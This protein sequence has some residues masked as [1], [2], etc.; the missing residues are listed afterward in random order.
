MLKI[1][2]SSNNLLYIHK[3]NNVKKQTRFI[4]GTHLLNHSS[5]L[6]PFINAPH[7]KPLTIKSPNT[8]FKNT[9]FDNTDNLSNY[10]TKLN[11]MIDTLFN[12]ITTD[13]IDTNFTS[14]EETDDFKKYLLSPGQRLAVDKALDYE[15]NESLGGVLGLSHHAI[16]I[17]YGWIYEIVPTTT[18]INGTKSTNGIQVQIGLSPLDKWVKNARLSN[19]NIYTIEKKN[20]NI[21]TKS[22]IQDIYNRLHN[23]ISET[24]GIT[25]FSFTFNNCE[26][27]ANY[28][29]YGTPKSIQSNIIH[30]SFIIGILIPIAINKYIKINQ[31]NKY[32]TAKG[33]VCNSK[34]KTNKFIRL[35]EQKSFMHK[36]YSY[37]LPD[38]YTQ[39]NQCI[40]NRM[41]PKNKYNTEENFINKGV[42]IKGIPNNTKVGRVIGK[43]IVKLRTTNKGIEYNIK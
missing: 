24:K 38:T 36:I 37:M 28:I 13:F 20:L 32:I 40:I 23:R 1:Y 12:K 21:Y 11:S 22:Y 43:H 2:K 33:S 26:S 7:I 18:I 42:Y 34:S 14:Y 25:T 5:M 39:G 31:V 27:E 17:G 3:F 35:K 10:L 16:Y 30:G 6:H 19:K 29:A 4:G 15:I 8:S 41:T 9:T